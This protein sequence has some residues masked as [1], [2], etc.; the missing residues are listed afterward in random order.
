MTINDVEVRQA[1]NDEVTVGTVSEYDIR[2]KECTRDCD[3]DGET[4]KVNSAWIGGTV[5]VEVNGAIIKHTF[6]YL[7]T[8]RHKKNGEQN[9]KFKGILTSLG[10]DVEFDSETKKLV[11]NKVAGDE[12][13]VPKIKGKIT[14]LSSN[15]DKLNVIEV[16]GKKDASRVKITSSLGITTGL[17]KD[18]SG[19]AFYNELPI[20]YITAT[21]VPDEDSAKFIIEGV[22]KEI[23]DEYNNSGST[24]GRYLVDLV[25]PDFFGVEVFPFVMLPSWINII[26]GEEVEITKEMFYEANN[27]DSFCKVGDTVKLSGDIEAHTFGSVQKT[28]AKKTFGGGSQNVKQGFDRV[29]WTIKAGDISEE[30]YNTDIIAIAL[31]EREIRL[32]N[33]YKAKLEAYKNVKTND[34]TQ[35]SSSTPSPKSANPFGASKGAKANPFG[36]S[37]KKSNP[38]G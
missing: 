29:E 24:T 30:E 12:G 23:A 16:S 20:K 3:I 17:N 5:N 28:T 19:L 36:A 26:D 14:W 25:V 11:Y 37:S 31:D 38:F 9:D 33:D 35:T 4:T 13:L 18:Q 8:I 15:N 10:Y 2:I 7:D 27:D 34:N 21:N 22:V 6:R 1:T 32:D